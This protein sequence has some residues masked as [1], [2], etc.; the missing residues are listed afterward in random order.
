MASAACLHRA[1]VTLTAP[2]PRRLFLPARRRG[3]ARGPGARCSVNAR[4]CGR[5]WRGVCDA[6]YGDGARHRGCP[7]PRLCRRRLPSRRSTQ[8]L[9]SRLCGAR[10]E[11]GRGR[12][13]CLEPNTKACSSSHLALLTCATR[14]PRAHPGGASGEEGGV[15][16]LAPPRPSLASVAMSARS[17]SPSSALSRPSSPNERPRSYACDQKQ[18]TQPTCACTSTA[19][20]PPPVV[21]ER[22][23]PSREAMAGFLLDSVARGGAHLRFFLPLPLPPTHPSSSL[24]AQRPTDKKQ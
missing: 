8:K 20:E 2:S 1:H 13:W 4:C 5:A 15:V 11:G 7:P 12:E 23:C 9:R 3:C 21:P 10:G 24:R 17:L 6:A 22:S 14:P 19:S 18:P 16:P